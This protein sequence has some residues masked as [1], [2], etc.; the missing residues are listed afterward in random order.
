METNKTNKKL[1]DFKKLRK[2]L[3]GAK[4]RTVKTY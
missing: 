4:T 2:L 3:N 1:M